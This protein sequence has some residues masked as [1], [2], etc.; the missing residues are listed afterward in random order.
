MLAGYVWVFPSLPAV[1]CNVWSLGFIQTRQLAQGLG[2][3][4]SG[5][6]CFSS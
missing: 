4:G 1:E 6:S 5:L 2:V 3:E